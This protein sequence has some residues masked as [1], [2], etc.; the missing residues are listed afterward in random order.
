VLPDVARGADRGEA[1]AGFGLGRDRGVVDQRV[2]F[3]IVEPL[4]DLVD[5]LL[6]LRMS[7]AMTSE[8]AVQSVVVVSSPPSS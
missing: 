8:P 1:R 3:A 2:Q 7:I 4:L 5:R 6:P